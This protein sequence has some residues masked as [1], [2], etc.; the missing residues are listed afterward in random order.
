MPVLLR[1]SQAASI[2]LEN[3]RKVAGA[4]GSRGLTTTENKC[5]RRRKLNENRFSIANNLPFPI[6]SGCLNGS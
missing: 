2:V 4:L 6:A 3:S 1:E 5:W